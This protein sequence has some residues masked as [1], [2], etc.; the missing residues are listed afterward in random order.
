MIFLVTG[1]N[2]YIG[3]HMCKHLHR[4]GHEVIVLDDHST[5]PHEATHAYGK[6][7]EG[8]I[9]DKNF[10]GGILARHRVDGVFH[11]A[12]R[13]VVSESEDKPFMY[14]NDNTNK[15][16]MFFE[17]LTRNGIKNIVFSSTSSTYGHTQEEFLSEESMQNPSN[18]YA[19]S[20]K[21]LE[22]VLRYVSSKYQTG[23][24]VLRYFNVAGS[25]PDLD[26]GEN[27]E[28]E[29][30]LIPN[31]CL[32]HI[33]G[34]EMSFKLFGDDHP[35]PDGTC[36]RDY[37]HVCDLVKAHFQAYE[38]LAKKPGFHVFNLGSGRGFSVKEVIT[39]FEKVTGTKLNY[40]TAPARRED[41]PRLVCQ[42]DKAA[43]ELGFKN[44]Y[45]LEDCIRHT[46]S[47]L[48]KRTT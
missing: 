13:S 30:H 36:I 4:L 43:R 10:V 20:K 41:P 48:K 22:D 16:T 47:Y 12:A 26:I 1:G 19:V 28:P 24:A 44:E 46:L 18:A 32:S 7:Y 5:S 3:S 42:V 33:R 23:V 35:T 39:A 17:A 29:T 11:F 34:K 14:F 9:S 45:G 38:Y 40:E 27:H 2:G 15:S 21:L 31:L 25:D 8:D 37:I 6:F